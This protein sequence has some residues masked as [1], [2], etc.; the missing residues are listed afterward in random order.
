[1]NIQVMNTAAAKPV[2]PADVTAAPAHI[3][4][5]GVA[6]DFTLEGRRQRVLNDINLAVPKGS[7]V[8]LIGPSGCG[9]STLLKLM[10]GLILPTEGTV[11]VAGVTPQEAVKARLIGLVF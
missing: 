6:V 5:R 11:S 10:A 4:A 3:A 9:K 1:M 2:V 7:F 8:S